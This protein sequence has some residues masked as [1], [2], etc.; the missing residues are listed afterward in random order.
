MAVSFLGSAVSAPGQG[1]PQPFPGAPAPAVPTTS[2]APGQEL[3]TTHGPSA[4]GSGEKLVSLNFRDAPL[5][6][7]LQFYS[8]I[9][10]RTLIKS[11]GINATITLRGQTRLTQKEALQAIESVLAMNNVT[12]VPMGEKFLKVV[13]PTAARQEAMS[14]SGQA[15]GEAV[16]GHGPVDQPDHPAQVHRD[17]RGAGSD[18]G[19]YPR[20]WKNPAAR[21]GQQPADHGYVRQSPADHGDPRVRRP[22]DRDESRDADL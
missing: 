9:T 10:G 6:Q 14:I 19:I 21:A 22:A 13:Q 12:L 4:P 11:P 3:S 7:V 2:P 16:R 17:R 15:A 5:D 18:P 1:V 8:E 20:L